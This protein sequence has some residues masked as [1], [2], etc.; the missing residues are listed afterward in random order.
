[1]T[2][3]LLGRLEQNDQSCKR[4]TTGKAQKYPSHVEKKKPQIEHPQ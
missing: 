1:V 2:K 3:S 4:C